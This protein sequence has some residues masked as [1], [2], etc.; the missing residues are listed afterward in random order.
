M[1]IYGLSDDDLDLLADFTAGVLDPPGYDRVARLI[2]T[3]D[4]WAIAHSQLIGADAA[5]RADLAATAGP[6]TMPSEVADR[7]DA[8]IAGLGSV[9]ML[10][11]HRTAGPRASSRA[12]RRRSPDR[13]PWRRAGL[14]ATG[15]AAAVV[16]IAGG[17]GVATE[18]ASRPGGSAGTSAA[19]DAQP[20]LGS[21]G[22]PNLPGGPATIASGRNYQPGTLGQLAHTYLGAAPPQ[23]A[24]PA[25]TPHPS[26]G[27]NAG[28]NAGSGTASSG[29]AA[30]DAPKSAADSA[31]LAPGGVPYAYSSGPLGRLADPGALSDCLAAIA[32]AHPGTPA[33]VDFAMFEGTPALVVVIR[34]GA[35][36]VVVAAGSRC[37]IGGADELYAATVS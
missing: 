21:A 5:V 30:S 8:A 31:G 14:L 13:S 32:R 3:D 19:R 1:S 25:P 9:S 23:A 33:V 22:T 12:G 35:G 27:V 28:G 17:I 20:Q 6:L 18:F 2:G 7:L 29:S 10:D 36:A 24:A 4:R 16:V 15:I 37:G 26:A 34:Q 11:S